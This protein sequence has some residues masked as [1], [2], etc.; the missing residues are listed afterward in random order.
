MQYDFAN[1][2]FMNGHRFR[3]PV[4]SPFGGKYNENGKAGIH[5]NHRIYNQA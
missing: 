5:C 4:Q 3:T 1:F 2:R